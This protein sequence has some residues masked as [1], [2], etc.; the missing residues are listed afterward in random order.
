[1]TTLITGAN[2]SIGRAL[3]ERLPDAIATD[4]D[5]LLVQDPDVVDYAFERYEPSLVFHL[6]GAK[7]APEGE[8]DPWGTTKV[9]VIGTQ[10]VLGAASDYGAKVIVASTCKAADPETAY[11]AS[12]LLAE[13]MTLEAGQT[14][15]RFYNVIETCGNVFETW[16][17]VPEDEPIPVTPCRR[18]FISLQQAVYLLLSVAGMP[19]GRYT[20]DPGESR[21][22]S[23]VAAE[24]Y[25]HREQVTIPPRRGDRL[26]E[27]R[28]ALS[29]RIE[30]LYDGLERIISSYDR[31]PVPA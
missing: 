12:K 5:S 16:R 29:E 9:N 23:D 14:V 1:M 19:S 3:A 13:R 27:P 7:H 6:A 31:Q 11:G 30:P 21:W 28:C 17:N 10:N 26:I 18:Y 4:R 22:M 20:V 25:P 15:A 8:T 2:G 24:H